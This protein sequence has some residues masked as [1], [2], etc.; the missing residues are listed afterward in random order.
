M[1]P[2][3]KAL[4]HTSGAVLASDDPQ[5]GLTEF[6]VFPPAMGMVVSEQAMMHAPTDDKKVLI[7]RLAQQI[8][9]S[10][11]KAVENQILKAYEMDA[12]SAL[13]LIMDAKKSFWSQAPAPASYTPAGWDPFEIQPGAFVVTAPAPAWSNLNHDIVGD[14]TTALAM[15]GKKSKHGGILHLQQPESIWDLPKGEPVFFQGG[16]HGHISH[17][18]GAQ[19]FAAFDPATKPLEPLDEAT[20]YSETKIFRD[21]IPGFSKMK[22]PCPVKSCKATDI[23]FLQDTIIHL[24]DHHKWK[25]E[26]VAEWLETLDHDLTFKTPEEM[27]ALKQEQQTKVEHLKQMIGQPLLPHQENI[28]NELMG[29]G[30]KNGNS[31]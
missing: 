19:S 23:E 4:L 28:I 21:L 18:E 22:Q 1:D 16:P 24:N 11:A 2:K 29:E 27:E 30:V 12:Q 7:A 13:A 3:T 6:T 31:D 8:G 26:R 9:K 10:V 14:L 17:I 20:Y 5:H 15:I 25:R